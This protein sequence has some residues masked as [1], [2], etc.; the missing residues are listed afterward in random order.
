MR[1][2]VMSAT[3]MDGFFVRFLMAAR[4][5]SVLLLHRIMTRFTSQCMAHTHLTTIVL[6]SDHRCMYI[7]GFG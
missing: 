3:T 5:Q 2:L 6:A 7:T 1:V 4:I